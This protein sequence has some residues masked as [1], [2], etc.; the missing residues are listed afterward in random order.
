MPAYEFNCESCGAF[1]VRRSLA[2]A[3]ESA[4]CPHCGRDGSRVYSVM[5]RRGQPRLVQ[6]A[7]ARADASAESP[8]IVTRAENVGSRKRYGA[9]SPGSRPWQLEH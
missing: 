9:V 1:S 3:G 4:A 8:G 7:V 2:E 6:E 5:F